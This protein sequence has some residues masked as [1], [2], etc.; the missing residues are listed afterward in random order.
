MI[1]IIFLP[2]TVSCVVVEVV[3]C[4]VVVGLFSS[5]NIAASLKLQ[6]TQFAFY[7]HSIG[8]LDKHQRLE[9]V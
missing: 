5:E 4:V 3:T 6:P 2:E 8:D 1:G 9:W 7:L